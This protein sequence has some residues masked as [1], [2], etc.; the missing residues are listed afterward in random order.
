MILDQLVRLF[1]A[2]FI[3]EIIKVDGQ[4][5]GSLAD[6]GLAV[7][8]LVSLQDFRRYDIFPAVIFKTCDRHHA[9]PL[10]FSRGSET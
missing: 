4:Q 5:R 9:S 8:R 10:K 6:I 2:A 7:I 1:R 3:D